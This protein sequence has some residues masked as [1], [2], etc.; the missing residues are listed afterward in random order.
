MDQLK[1]GLT[2]FVVLQ[3]IRDYPLLMKPLF[4]S[5]GKTGLTSSALLHVFK[6]VWS[7]ERSNA[8]KCK[9][10]VIFGWTNYVHEC[11]STG[12]TLGEI[13]ILLESYPTTQ[14]MMKIA[15][16]GS[17]SSLFIGQLLHLFPK[18]CYAVQAD[19]VPLAVL[20]IVVA[21]EETPDALFKNSCRP[22]SGGGRSCLSKG[23]SYKI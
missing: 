9:E 21:D 12:R 11:G 5:D 7:P 4:Q 3:L 16:R 17:T 19:A 18:A 22:R 15:S 23:V 2:C 14:M 1:D 10:P 13:C 20:H 8:R 6:I